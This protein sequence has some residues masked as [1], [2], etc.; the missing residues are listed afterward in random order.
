MELRR[1][2]RRFSVRSYV[3]ADRDRVLQLFVEVPSTKIATRNHRL[4]RKN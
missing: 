2:E 4:N 3:P 1:T